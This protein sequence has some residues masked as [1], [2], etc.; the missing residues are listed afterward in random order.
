MKI[1][2]GSDHRGFGAKEQIKAILTQLGHEYIDVGA[3]N[4]HPTDYPDAAYLA[5]KEVSEGRAELAILSCGTGAG[6]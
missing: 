3:V 6:P 4:D 2:V 5:A 1:A